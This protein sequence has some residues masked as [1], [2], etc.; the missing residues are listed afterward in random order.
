M[1]WFKEDAGEPPELLQTTPR[2]QFDEVNR[3][4]RLA[5]ANHE[6][7]WHALWLLAR[8][9]AVRVR[10]GMVNCL[11][12]WEMHADQLRLLLPD[13]AARQGKRSRAGIEE[14][15]DRAPRLFPVIGEQ[16][17]QGDGVDALGRNLVRLVARELKATW[18]ELLAVEEVV[19]KAADE[20]DGE[21]PI[22]PE[23]RRLLEMR[24]RRWRPFGRAS[25]RGSRTW[26][27][28]RSPTSRWP[29]R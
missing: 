22:L 28:P 20:F 11:R 9:D 19:S 21:E 6:I 13:T 10:L 27:F 17:E 12:L 4:A 25:A 24:R 15:L 14:L 29:V 16:D 7:T 5:D 1:R 26:P 8:L 23:T 2:E 18:S 3:L